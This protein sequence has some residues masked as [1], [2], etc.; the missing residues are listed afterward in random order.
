MRPRPAPAPRHIPP[1]ASALLA[2]ALT[3]GAAGACSP[4]GHLPASS[5]RPP[6]TGSTATGSTATGPTSPGSTAT[7]EP[8]TLDE[9]AGGTT[10]RVRVGTAVVIRLHSTYWSVPASSDPRT[11]APTAGGGTSSGATCH[12]PGGGCGE[13]AT[14]FLA[15]RSGTVHVTASRAICGEAMRCPPGQGA[16]DVTVAVA[17]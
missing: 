15:L 2:V 5:D 6:A 4:T 14:H 16:Y 9:H 11:L 3:V 17:G 12:P 8:I 1:L 13:S 7:P 10:V